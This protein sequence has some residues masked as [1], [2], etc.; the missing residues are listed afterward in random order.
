M[1][2]PLTPEIRT[3]RI[4]DKVVKVLLRPTRDRTWI[5]EIVGEEGTL[6][7]DA[8]DSKEEILNAALK[9]LSKSLSSA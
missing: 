2:K 5:A 4:N 6:P 3:L 9:Y 7:L 1:K 8:T